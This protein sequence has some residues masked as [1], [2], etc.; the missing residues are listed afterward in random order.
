MRRYKNIQ[1]LEAAAELLGMKID[2]E[3]MKMYEPPMR[4]MTP[5]QRDLYVANYNKRH[6]FRERDDAQDNNPAA[7]DQAWA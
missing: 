4:R 7:A 2:Y 5:H 6:F 3:T 1:E